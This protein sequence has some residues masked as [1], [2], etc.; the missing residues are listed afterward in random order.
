MYIKEIKILN[1]RNFKKVLIPFHEGVNVIIGHNNTG[2]S[3]LLRAIGLVLGHSD[4]RRLSTSDL[5]YETDVAALQL[6]SPCIQIT[7][8]LR[9]SEDEALDSAE[10]GL[11]SSMMTDPALSEEAELRYKFQLADAQEENYKADVASATT[12]KEIWKIIDRDYIRLY[13][14]SRLG[15]S[16][17]A[18]ISTNDVLGQIDFQFLDAIR[19]V[20]HD[21]YAGYNPL[22]RDVLNFFIDY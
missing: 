17:A 12:A 13:R 2:K 11:F 7:L 4:G 14:S 18:G 1:F 19:D 3:N 16:Q 10:M 21:L 22:L 15:G 5:F 8:V 6:Q 20:S 9:R